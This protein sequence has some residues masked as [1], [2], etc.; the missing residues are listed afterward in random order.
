[1]LQKQVVHYPPVFRLCRVHL[2]YWEK[3]HSIGATSSSSCNL[4]ALQTICL[5]VKEILN[6]DQHKQ[7]SSPHSCCNGYLA[8]LA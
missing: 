7:S 5:E 4:Q 1:M 3:A 8:S 2:C 6:L